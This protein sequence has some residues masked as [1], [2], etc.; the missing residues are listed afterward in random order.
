MRH[1]W[2][3]KVDRRARIRWVRCQRCGDLRLKD[4]VQ[5]RCEPVKTPPVVVRPY[6]LTLRQPRRVAPQG[7]V[8]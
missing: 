1:E 6:D 3:T 2:Q 7:A 4:T 5:E 8:P